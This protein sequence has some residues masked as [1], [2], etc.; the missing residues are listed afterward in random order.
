[1]E[2]ERRTRRNRPAAIRKGD[3]RSY[4][5]LRWV[6]I[7]FKSASVFLAVAVFAEC[8]AGVRT[9][10]WAL[11]PLLLGEAARVAIFSIF[12]WAGGDLIRLLLQI[13]RDLR[14]ERVILARIAHRTDPRNL[15]R[16]LAVEADRE[17]GGV[18][19]EIGEGDRGLDHLDTEA[20][21][22]AA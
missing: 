18:M 5:S 9:E 7:L 6:S 10:G 1:M 2:V 20:A 4:T 14:A 22:E 21:G 3:H 19:I 11:L 8:V 12:L 13:G 16:M 15:E 17:E